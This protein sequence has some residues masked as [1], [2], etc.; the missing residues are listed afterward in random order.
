MNEDDIEFIQI[1]NIIKRGQ[2]LVL[3]AKN[4][5]IDTSKA[6]ELINE[7]KYALSIG[8]RE[9]AVDYAKKCMLLI[10]EKKREIDKVALSQDGALEKLTKVELRRKC[11]E[12]GLDPVG[13]KDELIA[14]LKSSI[15]KSVTAQELER[16]ASA[17]KEAQ[18][19]AAKDLE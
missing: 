4:A 18:E 19:Q 17:E 15:N 8:N 9:S 7:A 1:L 12:L 14:R 13:L 11:V 10:I 3:Q 5:G 16:M 2:R 6:E